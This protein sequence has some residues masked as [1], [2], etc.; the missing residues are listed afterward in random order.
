HAGADQRR[1]RAGE[2]RETNLMGNVAEDGELD[3]ARIPEF[4]AGLGLD[5]IEPAIDSAAHAEQDGNEPGLHD[6]TQ[7]D[8]ELRR[9]WKL[10]TEAVKNIAEHRHDL[11]EQEDGDAD[12]HD[13]HDTR[14]H[15]GGLDLAAQARGVFQVGGETGENFSEQTAFFTS[16]DHA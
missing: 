4:A 12:G 6:I 7:L 10:G 8:Q 1:E 13:G 14:I 16:A 2:P 15:H 3:A 5:E 9:G 11:D